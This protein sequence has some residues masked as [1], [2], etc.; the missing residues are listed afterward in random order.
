ME[1]YKTYLAENVLSED[2]VVSHPPSTGV[3]DIG[4]RKRMST[5]NMRPNHRSRTAC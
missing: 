3:D 5:T 4:A 2:K 1:D